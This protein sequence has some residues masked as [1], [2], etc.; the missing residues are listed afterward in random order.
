MRNF[1]PLSDYEK[2][3]LTKLF[4]KPFPG[5]KELIEQVG[6]SKV[7]SI[8]E[9]NDNWGS[10][11]FKTESHKKANTESR[12]PIQG[13][14]R[15]KDGIEIDIFLHVVNGFINEVEIVRVDNKPIIKFDPNTI[16]TVTYAE[17]VK[18]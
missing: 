13:V 18:E 12:V 2:Q 3:I 14:T 1:R 17:I 9:Y 8:D 4:K 11:E 15:D 5:R 10:I 16:R 7:K 6:K